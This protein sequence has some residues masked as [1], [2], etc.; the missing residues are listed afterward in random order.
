MGSRPQNVIPVV[1][2]E[3]TDMRQVHFLAT[4]LRNWVLMILICRKGGNS[5][6]SGHTGFAGGAKERTS[7]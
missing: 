6:P 2:R 5:G 1:Y 7:I 3:K 4:F